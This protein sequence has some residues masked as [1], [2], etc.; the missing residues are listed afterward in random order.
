MASDLHSGQYRKGTDIPYIAHLMSVSALVLEHG[1]S[2]DQAIAALLH[3]AVEDQGGLETAEKIRGEFG[4]T[5]AEIVLACSDS[6]GDPKPPW[7]ERKKSYLAHLR[8]AQP[9]VLLVSLADKVHNARAILIDYKRLG[10]DLWE[11]FNT[12]REGIIWYYN[13]LAKEF[14]GL[15][16]GPLSEELCEIV[17]DLREV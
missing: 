2:E 13:S 7:L 1:G 3:D 8:S 9:E 6:T 14:S 17:Q 15:L 11:R 4:A 10:D 16:P 5:V 12:D